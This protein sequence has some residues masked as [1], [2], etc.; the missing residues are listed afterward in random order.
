M[1]AYDV[2]DEIST[3]S[4]ERS[5]SEALSTVKGPS[6]EFLYSQTK[7][8][9]GR[10]VD[11]KELRMMYAAAI[12]VVKTKLEILNTEFNLQYH[13]NP[14]SSVQTRLKSTAST[15]AKLTKL[16]SAITIDSIEEKIND[17]AGVRVICSYID[18][19]YM[20]ADAITKQ[21]DVELITKKDYIKA[22]KENGYRSLHLLIK[23]PVFLSDRNVDMKVEVQIRT[24]AM[25]FWASLEHQLRYKQT[26]DEDCELSKEL[27]LC[28]E[29]INSTDEKMLSL[30]ER[31]EALQDGV[32]DD[33]KLFEKF[34]KF[35]L[36]IE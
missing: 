5:V 30:R 18:D 16:G 10:M 31:V 12:K 27:K 23:V 1:K 11:Y 9:M 25:D 35:D 3:N 24:I 22:P 6:L 8:I 33:E 20:I 32:S 13:R 28:A 7:L 15:M 17:I 34:S 14:I 4:D 26:F 21:H 36:P 2:N 29:I 19:I